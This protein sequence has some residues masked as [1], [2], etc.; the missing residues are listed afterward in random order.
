M[1]T[2]CNDPRATWRGAFT[3]LALSALTLLP[4]SAGA[5]TKEV[6]D[7][8]EGQLRRLRLL[9]LAKTGDAARPKPNSKRPA[10]SW[11]S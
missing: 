10:P 4:S 7:E 5:Q 6:Q 3:A 9:E 2:C 1:T 8:L 11:R